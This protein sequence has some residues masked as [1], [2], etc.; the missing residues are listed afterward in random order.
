[1]NQDVFFVHE[2]SRISTNVFFSTYLG[3]LHVF[4]VKSQRSL[5]IYF[6]DL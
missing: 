4:L 3:Y 1:M 6:T 2:F 5:V